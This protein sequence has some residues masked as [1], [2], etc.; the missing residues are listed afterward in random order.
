M[1]W[2]KKEIQKRKE[3]QEAFLWME[4][5]AEMNPSDNCPKCGS[6]SYA[7]I[8]PEAVQCDDCGEVF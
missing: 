1:G 7:L 4:K 6:K 8:S 2:Y 3:I 5:F